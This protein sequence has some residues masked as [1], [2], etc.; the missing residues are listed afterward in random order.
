MLAAIEGAEVRRVV[1]DEFD[2]GGE[3]GAR[4]GSLDQVVAQQR[5]AR[6]APVEYGMKRCNFV[7]AFTGEDALAI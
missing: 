1:I 6:E 7:D 3:A 4:V 5:I 2:V